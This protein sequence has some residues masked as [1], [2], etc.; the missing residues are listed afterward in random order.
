MKQQSFRRAVLG[1]LALAVLVVT[2]GLLS[3]LEVLTAEFGRTNA[4]A[5]NAFPLLAWAVVSLV[6]VVLLGTGVRL[7][8]QF[9]WRL[10]AP[11]EAD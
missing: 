11:V 10:A 5:S 4:F 1:L 3:L 2:L 9:F 6:T 8:G 7:A